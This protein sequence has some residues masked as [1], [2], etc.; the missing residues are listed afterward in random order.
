MKQVLLYFLLLLQALGCQT[1]FATSA[2]DSSQT[3][4][5]FTF[6]PESRIIPL[7]TADQR[8][9]RLSIQYIFKKDSAEFIGSMGG[10][11]PVVNM[12]L[13][14][15]TLQFSVAS[16][17]YTT[18]RRS[19]SAGDLINTDFFVDLLL[20]LKW[21]E[22]FSF[23]TG[24]GHTSQH[25]SDDALKKFGNLTSI[26]YV[27]DYYQLFVVYQLPRHSLMTYGG[28]YYNH[29][30]KTTDADQHAFDKSGTPI[31]QLGFEH[32]P[33]RIS[34]KGR[35]YYAGDIKFHGEFDYQTTQNLQVGV[36]F[37]NAQKKTF[38]TALNWSSG[39]EERG[40]FYTQ[41]RSFFTLGLY[42]DF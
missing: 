17:L 18:L 42:F 39:Y 26:N 15:R 10:V 7:F 11:F 14:P 12:Q 21:N 30:F 13:G 41:Q 37:S 35:V 40:Q 28:V 3:Q 20:D 22:H 19:V 23:R 29:N 9:H 38:R 34:P 5:R 6:I 27:R 33:F 8:A 36:K 31:F 1:V 16:T 32:A 4:P 24:M 25:L 2:E